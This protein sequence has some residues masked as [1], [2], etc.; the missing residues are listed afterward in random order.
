MSRAVIAAAQSM[1]AIAVTQSV[2]LV[3]MSRRDDHVPL[4]SPWAIMIA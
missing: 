2:V 4:A 1:A 3:P